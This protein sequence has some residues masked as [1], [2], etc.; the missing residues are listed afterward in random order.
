ML[1]DEYKLLMF[2]LCNFLQSLVCLLQIQTYSPNRWFSTHSVQRSAKTNQNPV[3]RFHNERLRLILEVLCSRSDYNQNVD[4]MYWRDR[5]K[6]NRNYCVPTEAAQRKMKMKARKLW[7]NATE[8]S[9][10]HRNDSQRVQ[11][12]VACH[13]S[14]QLRLDR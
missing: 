2:S 12:C 14:G 4:A 8:I 11:L 13:C 9:F 7:N 1:W 3:R 6:D 5:H 10:V